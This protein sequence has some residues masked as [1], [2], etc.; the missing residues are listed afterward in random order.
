MASHRLGAFYSNLELLYF[1]FRIGIERTAI[2]V[3]TGKADYFDTYIGMLE[4]RE[5]VLLACGESNWFAESPDDTGMQFTFINSSQEFINL[6][7]LS[8][9]LPIY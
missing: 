4:L 3:N 5:V 8:K 7:G 6:F 2:A 1:V 9:K